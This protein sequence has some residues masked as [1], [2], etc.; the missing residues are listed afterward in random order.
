MVDPPAGIRKG[1]AALF[2]IKAY[3]TD[4]AADFEFG[5]FQ[6]LG[7]HVSHVSYIRLQNTYL[8][9]VFTPNI[10]V[11]LWEIVGIVPF[12]VYFSTKSTFQD[13][14]HIGKITKKVGNSFSCSDPSLWT[15]KRMPSPSGLTTANASI[16]YPFLINREG[17]C[18]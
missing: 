18:I 7:H 12:P 9:L 17:K 2:T 3:V 15:E 5:A 11:P 1:G 10:L 6:P 14:F 4:P 16:F 13:V 8:F